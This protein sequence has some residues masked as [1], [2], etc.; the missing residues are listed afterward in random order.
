[1]NPTI[2]LINIH[3]HAHTRLETNYFILILLQAA[4]GVI[5]LRPLAYWRYENFLLYLFI[6]DESVDKGQ[7][8]AGW[9][10][11]RG[12]EVSLHQM[13]RNWHEVLHLIV[14][15]CCRWKCSKRCCIAFDCLKCCPVG[16]C[17]RY[18]F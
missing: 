5:F 13:F 12:L 9:V 8:N 10:F 6:I 16:S 18:I 1:M 2:A 15:A 7:A 4:G 3:I 14:D 17:I 11:V